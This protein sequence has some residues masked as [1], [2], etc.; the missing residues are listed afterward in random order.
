MFC[1]IYQWQIEK[2]LDK[3]GT[4]QPQTQK[5]L[6]KCDTCRTFYHQLVRLGTELKTAAP[7]QL[8]DTQL[9]QISDSVLRCLSGEPAE[10]VPAAGHSIRTNRILGTAWKAA[11]ALL[12]A[13]TL[14]GAGYHF[15]RL[16]DGEP[17]GPQFNP[18]TLAGSLPLE[19][20][21]AA[22]AALPEKSILSEAQK[23]SRDTR[24]ASAFL[25]NCVPALPAQPQSSTVTEAN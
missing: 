22:L 2:E 7:H 13:A 8:S 20:P 21:Y 6:Q 25:M 5:H 23:L 15:F 9:R 12:I 4:L 19:A 16:S 1:R 24:Q 17:T 10:H 14:L 11:A 3:Y 18:Q